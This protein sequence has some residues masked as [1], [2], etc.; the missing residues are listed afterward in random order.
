MA[1]TKTI[2]SAFNAGELSPKLYGRVDLEQYYNGCKSLKNAIVYPQGGASKR[3]GLESL[4]NL[5][6]GGLSPESFSESRIEAFTFNSLEK[7]V[8]VFTG[9]GIINVWEVGVEPPVLVSTIKGTPYN[10]E[11]INNISLIQSQDSMIITHYDV[12][13]KQLVR[14]RTGD[15]TV[16]ELRDLPLSRIPAY[17]FDVA[18]VNIWDSSELTFNNF[19]NGEKFTLQV[20]KAFLEFTYSYINSGGYRNQSQD[21]TALVNELKAKLTNATVVAE[22]AT[23]FTYVYGSHGGYKKEYWQELSKIKITYNDGEG[24]TLSVFKTPAD[25]R[26]IFIVPTGGKDIILKPTAQNSKEYKFTL[27]VTEKENSVVT[28]DPVV[29]SY[30]SDATATVTEILAGLKVKIEA[31]VKTTDLKVTTTATELK[32]TPANDRLIYLSNVSDNLPNNATTT[33]PVW[34]DTRGYPATCALHQGRL[35]FGG[36]KSRPQT[37]WA[38]RSGF[39]Y[40]FGVEDPNQLLAN[41]ALDLTLADVSSNLITGL[42]S[43]KDLLVFT[44]GGVFTIKG[45][46]NLISPASVFSTKESEYGSKFAKPTQ[47]DNST[48]YLQS[49]GAQLNSL[50]YDFARDSYLTSPQALLSDHL[51]NTPISVSKINAGDDYNSNYMFVLN[52][53]GTCAL[54]NRLES[55]ATSTW[56]PFTTDGKI[57]SLC[58]VYNEMYCL[59]EREVTSSLGVKSKYLMLER[60]YENEN[61]AD[62]WK[63]Y[64][65]DTP[66]DT[67]TLNQD[68]TH[69]TNKQVSVLSDGYPITVDVPDNGIITLPFKASEVLMG[70]PIDFEIETM[71]YAANLQSG[72]SRFSRKRVFRV[73]FDMYYSLGFNVEYAGRTY[74]VADRKMGFKL[75]EPPKPMEGLKEVR[76]LGFNTDGNVKITSKDALP[77][78]LRSLQI[79]VKVTG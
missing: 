69:F 4:A 8:V 10:D 71:P 55:Q 18:P 79:E 72:S 3:Y 46:N 37:L 65:F 34:S 32:M 58:G 42:V 47:M 33:E 75:G 57:K 12:H 39:Y 66:T 30:T 40:D 27:K 63:K 35:W 2:T 76:L 41:D 36:S 38:S 61:Y 45:E 6:Y 44:N 25:D 51:L 64:K 54:F 23:L 73:L 74:K 48:F 14:N 77:V 16:W 31:S 7:Y 22:Y 59:V 13:P 52:S 29:I 50:N 67:I 9:D 5:T 20:D 78:H 28:V 17:S 15:S 11:R 53:N 68:S 26:K 70:L 24:Q 49:D 62:G 21:F 1:K 56:T 60:Y 43:Q 19:N